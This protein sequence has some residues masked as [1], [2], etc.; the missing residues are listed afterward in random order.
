MDGLYCLQQLVITG[1]PIMGPQK[2]NHFISPPPDLDVYIPIFIQ[3]ET[4][5]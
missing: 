5:I 4:I 1:G 2:V 3:E